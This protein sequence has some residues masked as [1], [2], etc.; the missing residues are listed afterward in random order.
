MVVVLK[1]LV[2]KA[3][4]MPSRNGGSDGGVGAPTP[5]QWL[6]RRVG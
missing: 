4:A 5:L 6:S 1:A 3:A 2:A